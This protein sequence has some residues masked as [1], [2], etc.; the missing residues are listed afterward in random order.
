MKHVIL[1][2]FSGLALLV[3]LPV[4][5]FAHT[6]V[7]FNLGLGYPVYVEPPPVYYEPPIRYYSAPPPV[8][9]GPR[10]IYRDRGWDH[11]DHDDEGDHGD[12]GEHHGHGHG[13]GHHGGDD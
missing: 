4:S 11:G 5:S 9:Y 7:H 2:T 6:D 12:R 1:K 13:H 3:L 10:V 8:Y